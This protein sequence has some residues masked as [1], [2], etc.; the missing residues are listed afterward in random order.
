MSNSIYCT[1]VDIESLLSKSG[2]RVRTNDTG[3]DLATDTGLVDDCIA[4]GSE[5]I[6]MSVAKRYDTSAIQSHRWVKWCCAVISAVFLCRRKGWPVPSSLS[7]E[8]G[9]YLEQLQEIRDGKL[10]IEGVPDRNISI[11]SMSNL[12]VDMRYRTQKM[13]MESIVS[14]GRPASKLV[15][16]DDIDSYLSYL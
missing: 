14:T 13:R 1:Q 7:E 8:Y 10:D 12:R 4:R 9:E 2:V 5:K 16:H 11:P 6:D 15:R 3:L